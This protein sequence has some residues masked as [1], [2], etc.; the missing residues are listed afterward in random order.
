MRLPSAFSAS[1][2]VGPE[3]STQSFQSCFSDYD[4]DEEPQDFPLNS[5]SVAGQSEE[6]SERFTEERERRKGV[7]A[8]LGAAIQMLGE[9]LGPG[10]EVVEGGQDLDQRVSPFGCRPLR[11]CC[12]QDSD[13]VSVRVRCGGERR[14]S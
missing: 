2:G 3:S 9:E 6:P 5:G 4:E 8:K 13:T 14:G 1:V 10:G 11:A 7:I 12:A